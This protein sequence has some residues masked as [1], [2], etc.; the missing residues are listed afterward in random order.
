MREIGQVV[1]ID[2][3]MALVRFERSSACKKCGACMMSRSQQEML[4]NTKNTLGASEGDWVQV[5][6]ESPA[7]IRASLISYIFPLLMLVAGL[8]IGYFLNEAVHILANSEIAA[9]VLGL[10][11]VAGAYNGIRLFEPRLKK[12]RLY[13]PRMVALVDEPDR[14]IKTCEETQTRKKPFRED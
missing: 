2:E 6:I 11:F 5:D 7:L 14:E 12:S 9:C 4:L 3:G 1:S 8:V 13:T 10:L